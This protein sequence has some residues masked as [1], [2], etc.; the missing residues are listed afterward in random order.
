MKIDTK[1][2]LFEIAD[3]LQMELAQLIGTGGGAMNVFCINLM[4]KVGVVISCLPTGDLDCS[5]FKLRLILRQSLDHIN[6]GCLSGERQYRVS[7]L[8]AAIDA[9]ISITSNN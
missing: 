6:G 2:A 7:R 3:G 9:A 4:R 5:S 8:V 1:Q